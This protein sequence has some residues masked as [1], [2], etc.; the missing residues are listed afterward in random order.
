VDVPHLAPGTGGHAFRANCGHCGGFV[1]WISK[2]TPAERAARRQH[3]VN[4]RAIAAM[5]GRPATAPQLAYLRA[6]GHQGDDPTDRA[7]AHELIARYLA[8]QKGGGQ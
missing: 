5:Q 8:R 6:L 4:E 2:Y 1:Q 3:A 7:E